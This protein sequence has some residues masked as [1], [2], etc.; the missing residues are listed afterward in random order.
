MIVVIFRTTEGVSYI[1]SSNKA[2][3]INKSIKSALATI[4]T[5]N[6]KMKN[7]TNYPLISHVPSQ[8]ASFYYIKAKRIILIRHLPR[9]RHD[10]II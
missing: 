10:V 4:I 8:S 2:I 7:K 3:K 9:N 1:K 6:I 5:Y